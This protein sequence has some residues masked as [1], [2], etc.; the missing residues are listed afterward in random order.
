VI[1]HV[2][3]WRLQDDAKRTRLAALR[4]QI[5]ALAAAMRTTVPGLLRLD[6]GD[7]R[8]A[9]PDAADLLLY[10]EFDSWRALQGYEAHP[11]HVQLRGLIAPLRSERR[12]VDYET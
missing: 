1:H 11:L 5:Q 2:V 10:S 7:N 4:E 8:A 12:V 9:V 6:L 3:M